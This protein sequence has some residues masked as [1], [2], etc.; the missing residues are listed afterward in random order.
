MCLCF[1]FLSWSA[2][3]IPPISVICTPISI[4]LLFGDY[5]VIYLLKL[6]I[7]FLSESFLRSGTFKY[8]E[9]TQVQSQLPKKKK[10]N[11]LSLQTCEKR[12][13]WKH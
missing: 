4:S 13:F 1:H 2:H 10:K 5:P 8:K 9:L 6:N 7:V 12:T 3:L 11:K